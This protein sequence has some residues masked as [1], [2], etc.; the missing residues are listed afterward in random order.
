MALWPC[1][2]MVTRPRSVPVLASARPGASL[3]LARL[4]WF[5]GR[6]RTA[7]VV[8]RP[9]AQVRVTELVYQIGL[10]TLFRSQ[11]REN[12]L[13]AASSSS[14]KQ[15]ASKQQATEL[16]SGYPHISV[17]IGGTSPKPSWYI[18]LT[19]PYN[20][21]K[22]LLESHQAVGSA[23]KKVVKIQKIPKS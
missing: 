9:H 20:H 17:S 8:R 15:A 2:S 13:A 4:L 3:G 18:V 16:I 14:S 22:F 19:M 10:T 7:S 11:G 23:G 1:G 6:A 21:T 12:I 5:A